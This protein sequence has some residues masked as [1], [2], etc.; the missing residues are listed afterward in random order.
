L[1]LIRKLT[2]GQ[3]CS[4]AHRKAY[5]EQQ[6][7]LGV[8]RLQKTGTF[9]IP[10]QPQAVPATVSTLVVEAPSRPPASSETEPT[11]VHRRRVGLPALVQP[12]PVVMSGSFAGALS[13]NTVCP[14]RPE[15]PLPEPVVHGEWDASQDLA[16]LSQAVAPETC[17][18]P[19]APEI[20]T[21][22]PR[23]ATAAR[24]DSGIEERETQKDAETSDSASAILP[25]PDSLTTGSLDAGNG[26]EPD[27][28]VN[29]GLAAALPEEPPPQAAESALPGPAPLAGCLGLEIEAAG[30]TRGTRA[31]ATAG[32]ASGTFSD[33]LF[34]AEEETEKE[35]EEGGPSAAAAVPI[36][37]EAAFT[38]SPFLVAADPVEYELGGEPALP[39]FESHPPA[40]C[41]SVLPMGGKLEFRP[42]LPISAIAG[43][44]PQPIEQRFQAGAYIKPRRVRLATWL[45]AGSLVPLAAG[46]ALGGEAMTP[47]DAPVGHLDFPL[48]APRLPDHLPAPS[49]NGECWLDGAV[50]GM[51]GL[52]ALPQFLVYEGKFNTSAAAVETPIEPK[53]RVRLPK[54]GMLPVRSVGSRRLVRLAKFHPVYRAPVLA[55]AILLGELNF[56]LSMLYPVTQGSGEPGMTAGRLAGR[57]PLPE[58]PGARENSVRKPPSPALGWPVEIPP[59]HPRLRLQPKRV[60]ISRPAAELRPGK[61]EIPKPI[62]E[63][64]ALRAEPVHPLTPVV[65]F[66]ERAPRDLKL[67]ALALPLLV[68]LAVH[69]S[70]PRVAVAPPAEG[71]PS[72]A[73][74]GSA[75]TKVLETKLANVKRGLSSR[76][77]IEFHDDF[78]TGLDDWQS[79]ADLHRT[80]SFDQAGFVRPGPLAIYTPT[81]PLTDYTFEFL[82]QLDRGALAWAFRAQDFDNYYAQRLIVLQGGPLPVIGL[83][84]WA[85]ING[86]AG[87][88]REMVLPLVTRK[89]M[90][91]RIKLD[92][93]GDNFAL[94]IQGHLVDFWSDGRLKSGGVGLFGG[95]GQESRVRWI[96]VSHQYDALGRLCAYLAPYSIQSGNGSH[97]P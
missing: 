1:P 93:R 45:P 15:E 14:S 38:E 60:E 96:Q 19:A 9:A 44:G 92:L 91:Y 58:S 80:W 18:D 70:L 52:A 83:Q 4:A 61:R 10:T 13:S 63:R 16:L 64:R 77:G 54:P 41:E 17:N 56:R 95:R 27:A 2:D 68:G 81:I 43:A 49:D 76:A 29:S 48:C 65:Q 7:K 5:W 85:V 75:I 22:E 23:L 74:A 3:F 97:E 28:G 26:L 6:Q 24:S 35:E 20:P 46:R 21:R 34:L 39:V 88:K 87:P 36:E 11:N 82:G 50:P 73:A 53:L 32:T 71:S 51:Q 89:D 79:K 31:T 84:S 57:V 94:S 86:K 78:R 30:A 47:T 25:E 90:L 33:E 40:A 12:S 72:V 59:I 66:W 8:E 69:P 55:R 67:L 62:L 37:F 42:V